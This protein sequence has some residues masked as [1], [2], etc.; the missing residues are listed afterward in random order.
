MRACSTQ[1]VDAASGFAALRADPR[2]RRVTR[3][4]GLS[5]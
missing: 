1:G 3:V 5:T 4:L 2:W